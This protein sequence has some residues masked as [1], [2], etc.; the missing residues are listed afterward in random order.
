MTFSDIKNTLCVFFLS[1]RVIMYK[2]VSTIQVHKRPFACKTNA[3]SS[4]KRFRNVFN[5]YVHLRCRTLEYV[6]TRAQTRAL[7]NWNKKT[8]L[9]ITQC[10]RLWL[11][12][13]L[14][15]SFNLRLRHTRRHHIHLSSSRCARN[16]TGLSGPVNDN[17]SYTYVNK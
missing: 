13:K 17:N 7:K 1:S 9:I 16:G 10:L 15:R 5:I 3:I 12:E 2:H 8:E 6:H 11:C 14:Q 4:A